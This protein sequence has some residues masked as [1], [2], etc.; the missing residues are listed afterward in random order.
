MLDAA[1]NETDMTV[2]NA[3]KVAAQGHANNASAEYDLA[4]LLFDAAD[5]A[6]GDGQPQVDALEA[7]VS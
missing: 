2:L 5:T 4:E 7:V 1:V 3:H 6:F